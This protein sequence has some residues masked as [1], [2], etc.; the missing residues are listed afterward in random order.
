MQSML[1]TGGAGFIGSHFVRYML[2]RHEGL[3]I[4][5]LDALTYAGSLDNLAFAAGDLRHVFV[6]G[7]I[8]DGELAEDLLRRHRVDTVVN[9][10]AESHVDRSIGD[11][12]LFFAVNTGG[13]QALLEA[14]RRCWSADPADPRCRSYHPGVRFL[15]V[16]TDEV[17]GPQGPGGRA[18]ETAPLRPAN[19]YA[20]SKA[21]ADLAV[22]AW[23]ETY[24]LP[25]GVTR[26][27]NNYGPGQYPEKLIPLMAARCLLGLPLPLYGDGLQ[28]RSWL[29]VED[30]CAALEAVLLRGDPRGCYNVGPGCESTNLDMVRLLLRLT[31]QSETLV[32]HVPDRPGHD[33]RYAMDCRK[34]AALGWAPQ[35][36]LQDGLAGTVDWCRANGGRLQRAPGAAAL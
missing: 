20:A 18:D 24:G 28:T 8:R 30:H 9:L 13:T 5:T 31:G 23:R 29:H 27:C 14:A 36:P 17:Y 10:A 4:V 25:A 33:R 6:R 16:S 19:P 1:V 12:G 3:K 26:C 2:Q 11:P 34:L 7:D 35:V 22:G 21:A 32:R 15:Q